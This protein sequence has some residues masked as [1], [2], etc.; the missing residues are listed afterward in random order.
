MSQPPRNAP[1]DRD[2]PRLAQRGAVQGKAQTTI[3][4]RLCGGTIVLDS[5]FRRTPVTCPHCGL[6]FAFDPQQQPLPVRG[7]RLRWSDVVSA[8]RRSSEV[9]LR[10][11]DAHVP[12]QAAPPPVRSGLLALAGKFAIALAGLLA[13]IG[14]MRR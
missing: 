12:P 14:W 6:R 8:N 7:I 4:C 13:L 5:N 10:L 9:S 11:H 2:G 1:D 3:P